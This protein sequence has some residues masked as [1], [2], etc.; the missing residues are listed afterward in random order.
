MPML[1]EKKENMVC[2]AREVHS[3]GRGISHQHVGWRVKRT[4]LEMPRYRGISLI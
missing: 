4:A 3:R 2:N 1:F